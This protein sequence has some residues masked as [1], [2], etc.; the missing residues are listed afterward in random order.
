LNQFL[1]TICRAM[2]VTSIEKVGDLGKPGILPNV[3]G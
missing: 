1:T 3:L 2:G